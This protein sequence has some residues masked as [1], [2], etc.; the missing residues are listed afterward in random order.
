MIVAA[1]SGGLTLML[2]Q[3]FARA[4]LMYSLILAVWGA[5]LWLRRSNPS[6][7]YLGALAIMEGLAVLQSLAGLLLRVQ[8]HSPHDSLHYLYGVVAV[9]SIP[10]AYFMSDHGTT[11]RDSGLF[12]IAALFLAGVAIRSFITG[13]S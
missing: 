7:G 1:A 10:T 8:G 2:H 9:V 3:G 13:G 11:R 12:A 4:F 6:G 5:F